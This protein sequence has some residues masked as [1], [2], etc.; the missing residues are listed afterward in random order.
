M[1]PFLSI[2]RDNL[3]FLT[4]LIEETIRTL[5]LLF[6][7]Y[8]KKSQKWLKGQITKH[9]LDTQLCS[10]GHLTTEERQIEHFVFWHER[11]GVLKQVFDEAEPST[12]PQWWRDRRRLVQWCTFWVAA[13]VLAL[14]T[15]FGL[16]QC[17]EGGLQV[18]KA[19]HP[20]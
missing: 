10:V 3:N 14:T 20:S 17:I 8:D 18:Y 7:E 15:I 11:L 5:S 2:R 19:Y 6:P 13:T 4:G 1:P 12:I 9:G 16:V